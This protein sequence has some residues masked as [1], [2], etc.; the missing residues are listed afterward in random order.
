MEWHWESMLAGH[1]GALDGG[2]ATFAVLASNV[3]VCYPR[4]NIELYL[5]I[6]KN[7]AILS[8]FDKNP[9]YRECFH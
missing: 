2:N 9:L 6:E 4:E 3:S 1:W 7:G 8:E 5:E